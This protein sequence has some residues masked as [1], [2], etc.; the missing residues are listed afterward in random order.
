MI[1]ARM[2]YILLPMYHI[3]QNKK[4]FIRFLRKNVRNPQ[5]LIYESPAWYAKIKYGYYAGLNIFS[6]TKTGPCDKK[7]EMSYLVNIEE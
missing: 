2:N 1:N 5:N 4:D 6:F 7:G 3:F